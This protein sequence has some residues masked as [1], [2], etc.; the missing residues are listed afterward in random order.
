MSFIL[1]LVSAAVLMFL[2]LVSAYQWGFALISL[3]WPR[4]RS[5]GSEGAA[6]KF[7]IMIPAHNEEVGLPDTLTSVAAVQKQG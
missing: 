5:H 4:F 1:G 7:L 6:V 2:A 3:L